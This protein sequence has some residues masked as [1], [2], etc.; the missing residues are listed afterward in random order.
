MDINVVVKNQASETKTLRP[1]K[2][3]WAK[4]LEFDFFYLK[5]QSSD[6]TRKKIKLGSHHLIHKSYNEIFDKIVK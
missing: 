4:F 6:I 5:R 2:P 1:Q 3:T